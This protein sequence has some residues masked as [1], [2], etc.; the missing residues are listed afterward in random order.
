MIAGR[1]G[2]IEPVAICVLNTEAD[3]I[4]IHRRAC[5]RPKTGTI[6]QSSAGRPVPYELVAGSTVDC[7]R[8]LRRGHH[9]AE[10]L[11]MPS[12][13]NIRSPAIALAGV[14]GKTIQNDF[15]ACSGRALPSCK[16]FALQTTKSVSSRSA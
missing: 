1:P 6:E 11:S 16:L 15:D 14:R 8:D 9:V 3:R 13:C 2:L 5:V 4:G 7:V 12:N 10:L